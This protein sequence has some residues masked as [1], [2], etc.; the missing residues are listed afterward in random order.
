[1][2]DIYTTP[3]PRV[4]LDSPFQIDLGHGVYTANFVGLPQFSE[5]RIMVEFAENP[6]GD[7]LTLSH[8]PFPVDL[9]TPEQWDEIR[10]RAIAEGIALLPES[11]RVPSPEA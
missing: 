6:D 7:S 2:T 1:M 4:P 3:H 5:V 11:I 8:V 9:I 10:A